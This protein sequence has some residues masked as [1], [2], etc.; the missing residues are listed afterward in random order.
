MDTPNMT[1]FRKFPEGC[2]MTVTVYVPNALTALF[3]MLDVELDDFINTMFISLLGGERIATPEVL[4]LAR[5]LFLSLEYCRYGFT[6]EQ[7][8]SMIDDLVMLMGPQP[9]WYNMTAAELRRTYKM[10]KD[11]VNLWEVKW[12]QLKKKP[13]WPVYRPKNQ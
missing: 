6:P 11:A 13:A 8:G 2:E 4:S 12:R 5:S 10:R 3:N 7:I 9:L 1:V